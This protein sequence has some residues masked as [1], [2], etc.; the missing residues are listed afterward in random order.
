MLII[1]ILPQCLILA[2]IRFRINTFYF[3]WTGRMQNVCVLRSYL[4]QWL[5]K[6]IFHSLNFDDIHPNQ[7][8]TNMIACCCPI[9]RFIMQSDSWKWVRTKEYNETP[10][11]R[12]I[13]T[14]RVWLICASSVTTHHFQYEWIESEKS[15]CEC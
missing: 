2:K 8:K 12:T 5:I 14:K 9:N 4:K 3:I 6:F 15:N 13:T 7:R 10:Q 1:I 11:Y